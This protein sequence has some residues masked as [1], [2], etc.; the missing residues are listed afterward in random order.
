MIAPD[1]GVFDDNRAPGTGAVAPSVP[2]FAEQ[3]AVPAP[4]EERFDIDCDPDIEVCVDPQEVPLYD[5]GYDPQCYQQFES[6]L[7]PY[8]NWTE[9]PTYGQ[10]WTPSPQVVGADF[11]PYATGG[12]WIASSDY[13]FSWASDWDWGWAPFHYGR[14]LFLMG[15][16][17]SWIPGSVWGPAWV[18]WRYGGGY[19]GWAPL[20]PAGV[21]IGAPRAMGTRDP[22]R[23]AVAGELFRRNP[24]YVPRH[25][26]ASI[27]SR[28]APVRNLRTVTLGGV[29]TRINLGPPIATVSRDLGRGIPTLGLR[30]ASPSALPRASIV[31]RPG[32]ALQQRPYVRAVTRG[33]G[34]VGPGPRA[35]PSPSIGTPVGPS[36]RAPVYQPPPYSRSYPAPSYQ[37]PVYRAP[38]SSAPQPSYQAPVYRPPV[39][40]YQLPQVPSTRQPTYSAP[41]YTPPR[42]SYQAP[43]YRQPA[44]SPPSYQAPVYRQPSYSAPRYQAPAYR[45]PS[46]SPSYSAPSYSRPSAPAPSVGPSYQRPSAPSPS[47]SFGPA[48]RRRP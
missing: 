32:I 18:D 15:M 26:A 3:A 22:W 27:W 44:Y 1:G 4:V 5:D 7:A 24:T 23:F 2:P 48:F 47:P 10:V 21:H 14:W 8:G 17:W 11:M 36:S 12:Q 33:G 42:P 45:A 20:P 40:S 38:A 39:P 19:V 46:P 43:V 6:T 41:A 9:D 29:S 31:A 28:T 37:A 25:V 13:G 34:I 30:N 16:G 35:V